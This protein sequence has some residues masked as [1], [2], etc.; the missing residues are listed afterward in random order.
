MGSLYLNALTS[1][2]RKELER[3]LHSS[4]Q[5]NCFI[6]GS[7]IDLVLHANAIDIDHIEPLK[8]GGKDDPTNFALTHAA[9]NR[10]KQASHLRVARVLAQFGQVRDAVAPENRGPNLGD[11]LAKFGGGKHE[12]C[13]KV[14]GNAVHFSLPLVGTIR[15]T[16]FRSTR[17]A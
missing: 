12:L 2:Q 11:V 17:T 1:D 10:S 14:D 3:Q 4:Q 6:C 13:L 15:Y 16:P 5:G 9:C 8:I 7:V